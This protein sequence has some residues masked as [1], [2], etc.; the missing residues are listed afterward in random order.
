MPKYTL[1]C[2]VCATPIEGER[3]LLDG[4]VVAEQAEDCPVCHWSFS[5]EYGW[6]RLTLPDGR[7][8]SW[9]W[10]NEP[11]NHQTRA[12]AWQLCREARAAWHLAHPDPIKEP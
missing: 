12:T 1:R 2:P 6:S 9:G 10:Q 8:L 4:G 5:F 3:S 11:I 7:E